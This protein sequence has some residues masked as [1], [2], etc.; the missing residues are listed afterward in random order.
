MNV[1][2]PSIFILVIST[3]EYC[4][5][6]FLV[7]PYPRTDNRYQLSGSETTNVGVLMRG[8]IA[9]SRFLNIPYN[10]AFAV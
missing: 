9:W 8:S 10:L 3:L 1:F 2:Y 5:P 6:F 7:S 4:F